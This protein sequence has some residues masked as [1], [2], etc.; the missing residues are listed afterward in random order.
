MLFMSKVKR[1]AIAG[2]FAAIL[3]FAVAVVLH[4]GFV[5]GNL[6]ALLDLPYSRQAAFSPSFPVEARLV[7]HAGG[8]VRGLTYT[9]SQEALD[10]HYAEGYRV[11]ELDFDWTSDGR[12]VVIHDWEKT[13]AQFGTKPHVFSYDEYVSSRRRDGLHQLTFEDLCK[14]LQTHRDAFVVTDT[15]ASNIRFLRYLQASGSDI[16]PQLIVQIYRM[17]ELQ[18]ARQL[19]PRAVWLT[20]YKY[21]MPAWVLSRISGVDAFV[22]PVGTYDRYRNPLLMKRVHFYVHSVPAQSVDETFRRLPDIYG[23]YV[24]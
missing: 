5:R 3:L 13:S 22:I 18:A 23:I 12:L 11:F 17:S 8:A 20:V 19:G 7:A 15:K 24:D 2:G 21:H 14:W 6:I 16:G 9:N 1:F 10:G 4:P